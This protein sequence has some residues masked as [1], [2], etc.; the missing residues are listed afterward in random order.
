MIFFDLDDTL[1]DYRATEKKAALAL[2]NHSPEQFLPWW[3]RLAEHYYGEFLKGKIS[4]DDQRRCRVKEIFGGAGISLDDPAADAAVKVYLE[5]FNGSETLF[6]DVLPALDRLSG[7]R[8]G[9]ITNGD[10]IHQ[11]AKLVHLGILGRFEVIVISEEVGVNKPDAGIFTW[12]A[13]QAGEKVQD[14]I[15][16]GD[17][18]DND[19]LG[20]HAA[21]FKLGVWMTR[22]NG[23]TAGVEIPE[24]VT[25]IHALTDLPGLIGG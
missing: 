16:V 9:I 18:L 2:L 8:L 22:E 17:R 11:R 4:F 5:H 7:R 12:A 13:R 19:A 15:H 14:C 20:A 23:A 21:G 10:M 1:L 6:E 25:V 24:G 3:S